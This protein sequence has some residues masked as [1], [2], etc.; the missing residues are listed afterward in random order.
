[1]KLGFANAENFE[2]ACDSL[3]MP[4]KKSF[5][6]ISVDLPG[7]KLDDEG[8]PLVEHLEL[9]RRNAV[10]C[11]RDLI[12]NPTFHGVMA[13]SPHRAF[14]ELEA[15]RQIFDQAWTAEWWWDMQVC[16]SNSILFVLAHF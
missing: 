2:A 14:R 12:G 4:D 9:W 8:Q 10:D 13:Y 1:M 11:V 3:P 5:E 16:V 15:L 6:C 7:D